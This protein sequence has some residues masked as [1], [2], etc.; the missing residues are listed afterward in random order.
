MNFARHSLPITALL[1]I[2]CRGPGAS[3]GEPVSVARQAMVTPPID[4]GDHATAP[5]PYQF[6]NS[7][8]VYGGGVYLVTWGSYCALSGAAR[9]STSGA[10]LDPQPLVSRSTPAG[11]GSYAAGFDGT[12]FRLFWDAG[13]GKTARVSPAGVILDSP[14]VSVGYS[15]AVVGCSAANCVLAT[16]VFVDGGLTTTLELGRVGPK[17]E[18]LDTALFAV[19]GSDSNTGSFWFATTSAGYVIAWQDGASAVW[20]A[21]LDATGTYVKTSAMGYPSS[22]SDAVTS[23]ASIGS[24]ILVTQY[25]SLAFTPPIPCYGF[26]LRPDGTPL[27][28]TSQMYPDG[29]PCAPVAASASDFLI[30]SRGQ[31][32]IS[33]LEVGANGA[34][35]AGVV[36]STLP[37][38]SILYNDALG[39]DGSGYLDVSFPQHGLQAT[40]LDAHG[41][42]VSSP[43]DVVLT[44]AVVSAPSVAAG[45]DAFLAVWSDGRS[46]GKQGVYGTLVGFDGTVAAR[47]L[48]LAPDAQV[49][50][51]AG[52]PAVAAGGGTYLTAWAVDPDGIGAALVAAG[53][54]AAAP[55]MVSTT[56]VD[57]APSVASSGAGYLVAWCDT[58]NL[59][60]DVYA[61]RV[62]ATGSLLDPSAIALGTASSSL[63]DG[64][65]PRVAWAGSAYAVAWRHRLP[66][67]NN[68]FHYDA[69]LALVSSA[70]AVSVAPASV[71]VGQT[72]VDQVDVACGPSVCVVVWTSG[73]Q[74][75]TRRYDASGTPLAMPA[76]VPGAQDMPRIAWDGAA[77]ELVSHDSGVYRARSMA[78]DGSFSSAAQQLFTDGDAGAGSIAYALASNAAG[79]SA[80]VEAISTGTTV[81]GVLFTDEG[82]P[83]PD[84]GPA[85][86]AAV[87][88]AGGGVEGGPK[89]S[90]DGSSASSP[91]GSTASDASRQDGAAPGPGVAQEG[92]PS[93]PGNGPNGAAG[94][95]PSSASGCGCVLA[96]ASPGSFE[97][98]GA[99]VL[100]S[101]LVLWR[102]RPRKPRVRRGVLI[103]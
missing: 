62:D 25:P 32:S 49:H 72:D 5:S 14:P 40:A 47:G 17:G 98:A 64:V 16:Q 91:E 70:G 85:D 43:V 71:S 52:A 88:A 37:V 53:G 33:A 58:R 20:T 74:V 103:E 99:V 4:L 36:T 13:G 56:A 3:P 46:P 55:I 59:V 78:A 100:L 66:G 23:L 7:S 45:S 27:D 101:F 21:Q 86:A 69:Q 79:E 82:M 57:F 73:G 65:F 96:G 6:T 29:S 67:G 2:A 28:A 34:P 50:T 95:A 12:N 35:A 44:P 93:E 84:G 83:L 8:V 24:E 61:A 68:Q 11:S 48:P 97:P 19:P 31:A 63:N 94:A 76:P 54:A 81:Y 41:K 102:S 15:G 87:D 22:T 9:V 42:A 90:P 10:L 39:S 38:T 89:G 60:S 80:V 75:W 92:G 26:R 30:A 1:T 51:A 77:F 18:T